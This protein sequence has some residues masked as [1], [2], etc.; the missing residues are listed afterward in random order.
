MKVPVADGTTK[1]VE[2]GYEEE[3]IEKD[4]STTM[5]FMISVGNRARY[6]SRE[7]LSLQREKVLLPHDI[8][9]YNEVP[10]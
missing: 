5:C 2:I 7:H 3:G 9:C 1:S 4:L 10:C 8:E 6:Y